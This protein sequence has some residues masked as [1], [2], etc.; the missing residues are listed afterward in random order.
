L[1]EGKDRRNGV[2]RANKSLMFSKLLNVGEASVGILPL[3]KKETGE[4]ET[5]TWK[6]CRQKKGEGKEERVG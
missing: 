2:G 1:G 5:T 3:G 6:A 4:K